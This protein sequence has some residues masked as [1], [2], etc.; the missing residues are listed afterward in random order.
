MLK[1]TCLDT[2]YLTVQGFKRDKSGKDWTGSRQ[3]DQSVLARGAKKWIWK[4][5]EAGE[6]ED[7]K[8]VQKQV[9]QT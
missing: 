6:M 3:H 2:V 9:C 1:N 5:T 8:W 4:D 7:R